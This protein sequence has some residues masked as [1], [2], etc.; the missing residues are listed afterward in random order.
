M[1]KTKVNGMENYILSTRG[2][3]DEWGGKETLR[4]SN[5]IH[6]TVTAGLFKE[7]LLKEV[8]RDWVVA[9]WGHL[10]SQ[11]CKCCVTDRFH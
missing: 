3:W 10:F 9:D 6:Y 2:P 7:V 11:T 8:E 5:T 4:T 1:T